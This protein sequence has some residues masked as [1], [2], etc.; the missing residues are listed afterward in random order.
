[1]KIIEAMKQIKDL[2][3][4]AEDLKKKIQ[5]NHAHLSYESPIYGAEQKNRID[6]WLQGYSDILKEILRLRVSVQKT[7]LSKDVTIELGGKQVTKSIAEWI[8]R[9]RDLATLEKSVWEIM[10]DKGL[11]EQRIKQSTNEILEVK[12][13]RYY[14]PAKRDEKIELFRSEPSK[15]D[16]TLEIINATTDLI[17]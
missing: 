5:H 17:E 11:Q 14:E 1:M 2:Q 12:I 3:I 9:R 6:E 16:S 8:H 4:K 10:N 13:L 15:V 7:N